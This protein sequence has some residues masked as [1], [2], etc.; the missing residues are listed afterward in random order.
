MK[1][2]VGDIVIFSPSAR[3]NMVLGGFLSEEKIKLMMIVQNVELKGDRVRL[4]YLGTSENVGMGYT[5][6]GPKSDSSSCFFESELK[7]V[8][9]IDIAKYRINNE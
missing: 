8:S 1:F 2:K 3:H 4:S 9:P 5:G 7:L 6:G